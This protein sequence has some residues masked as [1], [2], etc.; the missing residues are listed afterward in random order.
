MLYHF[1]VSCKT[2]TIHLSIIMKI[3]SWNWTEFSQTDL[4]FLNFQGKPSAPVVKSKR[5]MYILLI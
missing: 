5:A 1:Q 3:P 4:G 2:K